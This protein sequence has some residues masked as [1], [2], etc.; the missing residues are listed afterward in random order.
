MGI[1]A[2]WQHLRGEGHEATMLMQFPSTP[3]PPNAFYR[4]DILASFYNTIRRIHITSPDQSTFNT[5]FEQHLISHGI[6]KTSILY[7]DGPSPAEKSATRETREA[8]RTRALQ[9]AQIRIGDM[10]VRVGGRRRV[11]KRD[12]N[13]LFKNIRDAFYW[14]HES[15]NSLAEYL[16]NNGWRAF[17]CLSEADTAIAFECQPNDIVVSGDSDM[18]IYDTVETVWRPLSNGRFLVYKLEEVLSHLELSRA[19]LTTLGIVSKNDYTSNL[20]QLGVIT[21]HKI[22]KSLE[23]TE[24]GNYSSCFKLSAY[25]QTLL[26]T[27][28]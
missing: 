24:A 7:I 12:F 27:N 19:K 10:E 22:V 23:K 5:I 14:S 16:R 25:P 4:I 11:R 9:K 1:P 17:I 2:L 21:N 26:Y 18:L 20:A 15:R 28:S 8:K 6:P 13:N 3:L